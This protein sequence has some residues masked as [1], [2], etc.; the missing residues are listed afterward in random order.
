MNNLKIFNTVEEY[1]AWK[2]GDDYVYPN[3][4]KVGEEVVYNGYPEPFWIEALE[5]VTVRF[6]SSWN[7]TNFCGSYSYDKITWTSWS[8]EIILRKGQ[9]IY[10]RYA[11]LTGERWL[12]VSGKYNVGGNI[13]S[14]IYG[15]SYLEYESIGTANLRY[16]FSEEATSVISAEDLVLV[17]T[18]SAVYAGL[19]KNCSLL[20]K[21]PK[22]PKYLCKDCYEEMFRGC[23]SLKKAPSLLVSSPRNTDRGWYKNMFTGCSDLSYIKMMMSIDFGSPGTTSD[24]SINWVSGVAKKGTFIANA[25]RTY[26]ERGPHGIPEGWDLYLYDEDNDRYVVKFKVNEIPYE[27]YTDE[28]RDV[29]WRE[30]INSEQNTN[31]YYEEDNFHTIYASN[32]VDRILLNNQYVITSEN[33]ILNASYTIGQRTATTEVTETTNVEE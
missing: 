11:V 16:L 7:K 6:T 28:P 10:I 29:K 32:G 20:I 27:F 9:K 2:D 31:G 13:V 18:I 30:F 14:L 33:I 4:C 3:I 26:F 23:A 5:D 19:F 15:E 21:A 24:W 17:K 8:S 1:Q 22:L 25:K 12:W